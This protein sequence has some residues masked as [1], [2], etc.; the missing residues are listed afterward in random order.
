MDKKLA[1]IVMAGGL[2]T[3]MNSA[4]PKHLHPVLGRRLIDWVIESLDL[5]NADVIAL[6]S[7]PAAYEELK[8]GVGESVA[9]IVQKNPGGTGDAVA[10][11][12]PLIPPDIDDIVVVPGDTPLLT[13]V[14]LVDL[15]EAHR[16]NSACATVLSFI[17]PDPAEYGRILRDNEGRLARIVEAVDATPEELGIS[18]VNSSIYV[19]SSETL[20]KSLGLIVKN[21]VQNEQYLTDVMEILVESDNRVN[22]VCAEDWS[23]FVGVNTRADLAEATTCL[24]DRILNE[25]MLKGVTVVDP[26]STWVD[27]GVVIEQDVTIHP[28]TVLRGACLIKSGAEVGP[29]VVAVDAR[30]GSNAVVGPFTYLRS[31]SDLGEN[32]RAGSFVE[33]KNARLDFGAK[34]PHLSYIGDAEIGEGTNIG[35]GAITA[36]YRAERYSTKQR[37]TIGRNVHTGSHNV[38]V[39]PVRIGDNA[40]TAAGSTITEDVPSGA[41]A[42]AR[43]RQVNKERYG[44]RQKRG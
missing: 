17:P 35:A 18:E 43:A 11:A 31:N 25:H 34:V 7:S 22:V 8:A 5:L 6:V 19:F 41:L 1:V 28:F 24:R 42:I 10:A 32:T 37:T 29:H 33:I 39:P 44:E 38:F 30:I 2:G 15:V 4:T 40:W 20:W 14:P 27:A 26:G 23:L 13:G 9:V 21:D 16:A 12:R 3:R 36:N